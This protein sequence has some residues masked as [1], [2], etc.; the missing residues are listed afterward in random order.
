MGY[1]AIFQ[2]VP[3]TLLLMAALCCG[4]PCSR[5]FWW[6]GFRT[7]FRTGLRPKCSRYRNK[8]EVL[9]EQVDVCFGRPKTAGQQQ[10]KEKR[11]RVLS[12]REMNKPGKDGT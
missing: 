6:I 11:Q 8:G 10:T 1:G 2:S 5:C 9:R 7:A 3:V 4:G 12:I